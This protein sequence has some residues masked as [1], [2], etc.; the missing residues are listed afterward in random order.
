MQPQRYVDADAD[1]TEA[2]LDYVRKEREVKYHE[3][4]FE[5]LARQYESAR[6]DEAHEAP[7]L[8]ILDPAYY[9]DSKSGPP[10]M[11]IALGGLLLGLFAGCVWVLL[12]GR[13]SA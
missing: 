4:L 5:M 11:I 3:A 8:Q 2:E 13:L 7:L 10:R 12:R 6:L 1:F 9:P